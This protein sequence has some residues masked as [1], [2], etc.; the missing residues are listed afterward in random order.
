MQYQHVVDYGLPN[1]V[2]IVQKATEKT[3]WGE[4]PCLPSSW[5]ASLVHSLHPPEN[6]RI[7]TL[8]GFIR[9]V[10]FFYRILF[11]RLLLNVLYQSRRAHPHKF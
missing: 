5:V 3:I 2:V 11:L 7:S 10:P 4:M 9:I 1:D 6:R 8:H